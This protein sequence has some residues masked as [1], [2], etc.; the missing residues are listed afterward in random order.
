MFTSSNLQFL[1]NKDIL[2]WLRIAS[3][4]LVIGLKS[5]H[6]PIRCKNKI[7][8]D[9]ETCVSRALSSLS[10]DFSLASYDFFVSLDWPLSHGCS[11]FPALQEV[12]MFELFPFYFA[13][14]DNVP[15]LR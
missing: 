12:R 11:R 8:R 5:S 10:I 6:H 1:K 7:Y 2:K 13:L 9:S 3:I 14:C 4:L 15:S